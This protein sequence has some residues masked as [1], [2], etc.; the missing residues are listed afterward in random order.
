METDYV[1]KPVIKTVGLIVEEAKRKGVRSILFETQ[2][3]YTNVFYD[4][5]LSERISRRLYTPITSRIKILADMPLASQDPIQ[6]GRLNLDE[7]FG[8]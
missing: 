2:D 8:N 7:K 4:G 5:K 3:K 1:D 6:E